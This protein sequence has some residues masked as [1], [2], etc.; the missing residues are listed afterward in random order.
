M[1]VL[2]DSGISFII[3]LQGAVGNWFVAPMRFF[4]YL[5][6]EEFF[7]LVLP[8]IYWSVDS[9]LGLRMAFILL[10]SNLFN[11]VAKWVFAGPRP[12]WVSS[13]VRA[14]WFTETTF[15][16]PSGHAQNAASVWGMFAAY[17][18][19]TWIWIVCILTIFLIGFSRIFL[20]VHFPHD[21]LFGWLLGA[22][23][24]WSF[25]RFWEPAGAWVG[26][27]TLN[28]QIL[29]AFAVSLLFVV[30]GYGTWMFRS[31]YQ[32]PDVWI[33]N[34][35]LAGTE[36]PDPVDANDIFTSAGTIF[37]MA[38]GT[39]WILSLGSYQVSSGD[40]AKDPVGKRAIRY[41]I[42]LIGVLILYLG[43]GMIFP[44]GDGFIFYL[45]RYIRYAL[46]GWW[47]AGGAPWVFVRFKLTGSV[48]TI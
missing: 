33:S 17:N 42:G 40:L 21:V 1:L 5:G 30:L 3:A 35:T 14:L 22:V 8:L 25:V 36:L 7:L 6:N 4:S 12:Y 48:D 10:T 32:V 31:G 15:G 44:R 18:K 43:L 13:H 37:G 2:I 47:V 19:R 29:I 20:G 41:V 9:A 28:Q 38:A 46:I 11:H 45:L 26:K 23:I 34:S 39:A 27:K 16:I 24:L